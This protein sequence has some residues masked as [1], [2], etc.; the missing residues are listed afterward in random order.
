MSDLQKA[1]QIRKSSKTGYNTN[2]NGKYLYSSLDPS[3]FTDS[4]GNDIHGR[5]FRYEFTDGA[6]F[7]RYFEVKTGSPTG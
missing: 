6:K 7:V 4:Y 2:V 5:Y 3:G 1:K